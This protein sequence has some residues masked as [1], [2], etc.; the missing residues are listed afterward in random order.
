[1]SN[2]VVSL[3]PPSASTHPSESVVQA[4]QKLSERLS[5]GA[6]GSP[7]RCIVIMHERG[8]GE[9]ELD[10]YYCGEDAYPTDL[11]GVLDRVKISI[12]VGE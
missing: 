2:N 1:M 6:L 12:L 9:E 7:S 5:E 4:L 11:L 8:S 10:W 3:V